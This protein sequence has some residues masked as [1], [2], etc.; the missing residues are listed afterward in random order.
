MVVICPEP[1]CGL[2]LCLLDAFDDVLIQPLVPNRPVVTLDISVLL[3]CND[4]AES[5][6]FKPLMHMCNDPVK[7]CSCYRGENSDEYDDGRQH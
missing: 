3:R 5:A 2:I 6:Q 4:P 1:L 7:I